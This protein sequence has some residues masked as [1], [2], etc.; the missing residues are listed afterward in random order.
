MKGWRRTN[1]AWTYAAMTMF[2]PGGPFEWPAA[3]AAIKH[4]Y[5]W[6]W[7][8]IPICGIVM[9]QIWEQEERHHQYDIARERRNVEKERWQRDF[10]RRK[11]DFDRRQRERERRS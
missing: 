1:T 6:L 7:V 2:S 3:R 5:L 8:L 9:P 10:D 4:P 11:R